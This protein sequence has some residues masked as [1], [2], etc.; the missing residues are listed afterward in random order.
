MLA[1]KA[2]RTSS[3]AARA[4]GF[5]RS[6]IFSFDSSEG[7]G[8]PVQELLRKGDLVLVKGSHAMELNKVVEE[9]KA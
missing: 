3:I 8:K 4:A 1:L 6:R 9:I 7:A 5:K 2:P